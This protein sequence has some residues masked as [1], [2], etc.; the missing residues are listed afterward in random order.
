MEAIP[1]IKLNDLVAE[2][3]AAA[4]KAKRERVARLVGEKVQRRE[5][6]KEHIAS[7]QC[8]LESVNATIEH[9]RKED[10]TQIDWKPDSSEA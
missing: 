1:E 5:R 8:E 9:L 3:E 4:V 7:L 2:Q 10:W 6:I